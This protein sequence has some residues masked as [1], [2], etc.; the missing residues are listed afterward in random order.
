MKNAL[1]ITVS[2]GRWRNLAS[3]T[4]TIN[5]TASTSINFSRNKH[6]QQAY[7]EAQGCITTGAL[8]RRDLTHRWPVRYSLR[9]L[10]CVFTTYKSLFQG[11]RNHIFFICFVFRRNFGR[12]IQWW[13]DGVLYLSVADSGEVAVEHQFLPS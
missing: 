7:R 2:G 3:E 11:L 10:T 13:R 4:A 5:C 1:Q 6:P 12:G 8:R 9:Y